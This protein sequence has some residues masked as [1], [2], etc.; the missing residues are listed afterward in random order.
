MIDAP[1]SKPSP[2]EGE[3]GCGWPERISN[4][5]SREGRGAEWSFQWLTNMT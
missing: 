1:L 4:P 5:L 2:A 3:R